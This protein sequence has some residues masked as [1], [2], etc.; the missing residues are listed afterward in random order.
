MV[1]IKKYRDKYIKM[2]NT[3]YKKQNMKYIYLIKICPI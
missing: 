3:K 2:K 1:F